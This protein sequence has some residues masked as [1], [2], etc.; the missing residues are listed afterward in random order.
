MRAVPEDLD[1]P[2]RP[3][4]KIALADVLAAHRAESGRTLLE[5]AQESPVLLLFLRHFGCSFCRETLDRVARIRSQLEAGGT[6]PVFVHLA[7]PERGRPYFD[8]YGLTDVERVSDPEAALYRDPVFGLGQTNPFSHFF[9]PAVVKAWLT[10]AIRSYGIGLIKEDG[11]Q[12]PGVFYLRDGKI[13]N[14]YRYRTIAD[15]VDYLALVG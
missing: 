11:E 2:T 3:S 4:E 12:M 9:Q 14:Y 6:R 15:Q 13:A 1:N 10:G 8:H 5:L 7:T